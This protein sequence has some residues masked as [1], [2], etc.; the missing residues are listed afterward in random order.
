MGKRLKI[1]LEFSF[2]K[3]SMKKAIK[4][5]KGASNREISYRVVKQLL[6][7][8]NNAS[9]MFKL[10]AKVMYAVLKKILNASSRDN[11]QSKN[12]T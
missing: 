3:L 1:R 12:H 2:V 9:F 10:Y 11:K 8:E 5:L 6:V 7:N 4:R